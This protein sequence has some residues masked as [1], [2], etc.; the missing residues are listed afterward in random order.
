VK[1]WGFPLIR[2]LPAIVTTEGWHWERLSGYRDFWIGTDASSNSWLVKQK[3][4]WNAIREHI[5]ADFAQ[6]LGICTQS[7]VYLTLDKH[8][9]PLMGEWHP[10]KTPHNV[11]IWKFDE[12]GGEPCCRV[13]PR[14][15]INRAR[16]KVDK[17]KSSIALLEAW[18]GCGVRNPW[19]LVE[20]RFL[21]FLCGMFEPTQ[22]LV[23]N[24]H[25][26]VQIDNELT[27]SDWPF[28]RGKLHESV[29]QEIRGDP[30]F[31]IEG[32]AERL[33]NLCSRICDVTDIEI[34]RITTAPDEFRCR[35]L[36]AKIRRHLLKLRRTAPWVSKNCIP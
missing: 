11:G 24:S 2:E 10:D 17:A 12:H 6:T 15:E 35:T 16:R 8:S 28:E 30:F 4:T 36:V 33:G 19:D 21:G 18:F 31:K 25:L 9:M 3:G 1:K 29:T 27:F 20:A 32:A 23:T 34:D 13:C 14:Y 26:W 5:Y 7:S 22:T